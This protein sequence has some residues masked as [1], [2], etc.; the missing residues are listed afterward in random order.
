MLSSTIS[1]LIGGTEP[2]SNPA[3]K[4]GGSSICFFFFF[5]FSGWGDATRGTGGVEI[6]REEEASVGTGGVGM[7]AFDVAECFVS[8][9]DE[10]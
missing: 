9:A 8:E 3:G 7:G 5:F 4:V 1:T 6:W 10:S 2:S